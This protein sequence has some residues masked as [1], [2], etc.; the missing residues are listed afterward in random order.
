MMEQY[1]SRRMF[2]KKYASKDHICELSKNIDDE[3]MRM[4][5]ITQNLT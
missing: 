4:T 3:S 5:A 2:P 1:S